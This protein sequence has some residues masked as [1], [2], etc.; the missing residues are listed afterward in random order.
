MLK[1]ITKTIMVSATSE[2]IN[3]DGT[4][5]IIVH[6]NANISPEGAMNINQSVQDIQLYSMNSSEVDRDFNDFKE[7]VSGYAITN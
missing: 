7:I 2:V 6:M 3:D 4:S 1:N 5:K